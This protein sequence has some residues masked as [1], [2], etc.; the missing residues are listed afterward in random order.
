MRSTTPHCQGGCTGRP[1]YPRGLDVQAADIIETAKQ[2]GRF[3]G[4]VYSLEAAGMVEMLQGKGPLT[5]FAPTDEALGQVP[6]AT[7]EWFSLTR[8]ASRSKS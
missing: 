7:L 5:V 6:L 3:D 1:D 8:T 2:D 4:F